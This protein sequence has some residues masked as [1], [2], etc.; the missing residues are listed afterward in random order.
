MASSGPDFERRLEDAL[1]AL[2]AP[3][4]SFLDKL[5]APSGLM[6]LAFLAALIYAILSVPNRLFDPDVQKITLT[7]GALAIWRYGWWMTHAVRSDIFRR[8]VYPKMRRKADAV[9]QSGWRP[10]TIHFM[11]TTFY[12]KPEITRKVL[13]GIVAEIRNAKLPAKVWIGTGSSYDERIISEYIERTAADLDS[14]LTFV[15]QQ[16]PGKRMAIG[17]VLRAIRRSGASPRDLIVFM[18]GDAVLGKGVIQKS[19]SLFGADPDLQALT[20]DEDVVSFGPGWMGRW[21]KMRFAQRRIAMQSHALSGKVLTLTGRM[22]MFRA[23][24][25]LNPAFIRTVEADYLDHWLWGRFRFLSGDDKSTWYYLLT[26]SAK[27][28]YV[29]DALV[30]TIEVIEGSGTKR[31]IANLRRWSGNMLRNGARAIALGPRRVGPF[32]WWCLV[33]QRIAIWTTLVS[34][35]LAIYGSLIL[36]SYALSALLWILATRMILSIFLF[37]YARSFDAS[38]PILL[39]VNQVVNALVKVFM[40]FRLARQNWANRGNQMAGATSGFAGFLKRTIANA[41]MVTAVSAL[42]WGLAL[43]TGVV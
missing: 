43:W 2:D 3:P 34:P 20:T 25:V 13:D 12:E 29:P 9:W 19:A 42:L 30:Y 39:Y 21:L 38:W 37:R 36:P 18:D 22:S 5:L 15:R 1:E 41:Q 7:I 8:I 32:I 4:P 24:H 17:I 35:V 28:T 14:P 31:M 11:M 33:D 10:P 40:S 6:V 23:M 26:Q 27:M 16:Q